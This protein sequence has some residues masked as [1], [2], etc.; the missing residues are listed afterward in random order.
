VIEN[1]QPGKVPRAEQEEALGSERRVDARARVLVVEDEHE[2]R[3]LIAHWLDT[4][5]YQVV[6]AADGRDAVDLLQAGLEPDVI[7]LDLTMPR[8][9]GR[10]FLE[11]MREQ[12]KHAHRRVIVASGYLDEAA[13]VA[14]DRTFAKP[15]RPDLLERELAKLVAD[16]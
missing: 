13:P 14:A 10:A 11:W 2:L 16:E 9:D 6:E 3:E 15:F 1:V 7:L 12:P 4:R 5:G 8:M